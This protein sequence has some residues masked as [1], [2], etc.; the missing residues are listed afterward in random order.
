MRHLTFVLFTLFFGGVLAQI[1]VVD[2]QLNPIA[3]A[4]LFHENRFLAISNDDGVLQI[5]TSS[6]KGDTWL[7]SH[8]NF[9]PQKVTKTSLLNGSTLLL[10]I[11]VSS[12]L[13]I[14]ITPRYGDRLSSDIS[15]MVDAVASKKIELFQPQTAADLL[16]INQKVYIQKS[17]QG[18]G[19]PMIRG[20][21]TNRILLVVDGVR[22]N[23][24]IFRAGNV[25]NVINI[26]PFSIASSEVLFGPA[27]QFYGSD[28]IGGVLSFTTKELDFNDSTTHGSQVNLRFSSASREGTW[29][30]DYGVASK[31]L[32]SLSSVSFSNFSDLRMG[33]NGPSEYTRP[34]YILYGA[35]IGDTILRNSNPNLQ[36]MSA[37]R[38][39]NLMQKFAYKINKNQILK[40]GLHWSNTSN[41]PRYD[42]LILR[43]NNDT[44]VN[45]DW[46]YGPQSWLMNNLSYTNT[47]RSTFSDKLQVT[48]AH[49]L[50]GES[51][52]NRQYGTIDL[53]QRTERL[54]ALSANL[55]IQKLMKQ[56][57]TFS[58]GGELVQNIVASK[59]QLLD[60][61]NG[62]AIPASSRY[63][64]GST[65]ISQGIYINA[66]RKWNKRL[67]TEGGVR[68]NHVRTKGTFD[69]IYNPLPIPNFDNNNQAITGSLSQLLN[70]AKGKIGVL[71]STA[72]KSPNIDDIAKVF[73]SNPGY[74]TIPNP[75]L[76]PEYAYNGEV[77]G[78]YCF[79]DKV[80]LSASVFYTYLTNALSTASSTINGEDSIFYDGR[81]SKVQ[82][83]VN[84]DFAAVYG[85]QISV[86]FIVTKNLVLNSSYTLLKSEAGNNEPIRHITPN[87][88]GT[89]LTYSLEK[90]KLILY[91][92]YNQEFKNSQF[93]INEQ[94]E[95]FLYTKDDNGLPYSPAWAILNV[96]GTFPITEN[97]F[98][99][100]A[101]ENILD[102]RYRPY[103][104]GITAPGRNLI[105][106]IKALL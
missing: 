47:K 78:E 32:T 88:G 43:G 2:A 21:A 37:Y 104:S 70:F 76:K 13:P 83:L 12:F 94:S 66:Q 16:N 62:T 98:G 39:F 71:V 95:G 58:Y 49:Q 59:G 35:E 89:S 41:I 11:K 20:F 10:K 86:S 82:T 57:L 7:I 14:I 4:Q 63:P 18:G 101:L 5:D 17:Q 48:V 80:K 31:K 77:N 68:Y 23:T 103:S 79:G 8:P 28:A 52:N 64:D 67:S 15:V 100:V 38:Q 97:I 93:T 24:A 30:F 29:H 51:R 87:F 81:L 72:F 55:D 61:T 106:S 65:W 19:S 69:P 6:I 54:S 73:D 36:V 84:Q 96:R 105:I 92:N 45:G 46:Y 75:N 27:S 91:T 60:I 102:K 9:Y 44:L 90:A 99:N 42:R 22:M 74:V 1:T 53:I 3:G 40:Y 33:T 85:S 50:F 25:Q 26:D 56:N 34:D